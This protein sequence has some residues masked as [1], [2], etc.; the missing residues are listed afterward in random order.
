MPAVVTNDMREMEKYDMNRIGKVLPPS[1]FH[2]VRE[3]LK[4]VRSQSRRASDNGYM[5]VIK[6]GRPENAR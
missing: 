2:T 4:N 1:Y 6:G 5:M 3:T